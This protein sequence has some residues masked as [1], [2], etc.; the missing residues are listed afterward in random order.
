MKI[1]EQDK[2]DIELTRDLL[3]SV[4]EYLCMIWDRELTFDDNGEPNYEG[5]DEEGREIAED[6]FAQINAIDVAEE[7][8]YRIIKEIK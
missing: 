1:T 7:W 6:K 4:G 2:R 8:L 3:A 5:L